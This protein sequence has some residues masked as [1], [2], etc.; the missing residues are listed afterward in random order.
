MKPNAELASDE[1][2]SV[3]EF[4]L[5]SDTNIAMA[6]TLTNSI[7]KNLSSNR[8]I[9]TRTE[10]CYL[11]SALPHD[12]GTRLGDLIAVD[13]DA[14]PL[15]PGITAVL[16]ATGPLLVRRLDR[17]RGPHGEGDG[18]TAA[19]A[20]QPEVTPEV[21]RCGARPQGESLEGAYEVEGH[22]RHEN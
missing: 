7:L 3:T 13:L 9:Q 1:L 21:R 4:S 18:G 20:G 15:P 2:S 22:G 5:G 12:D 14:E 16:G 8:K 11:G 10:V 6:E 17:Q 19:G